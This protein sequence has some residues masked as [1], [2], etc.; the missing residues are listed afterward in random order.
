MR[1][2]LDPSDITVIV[3]TREQRPLDLSPLKMTTSSLPTGDYSIKGMEEVVAIERK[4]LSDLIGCIGRE[5]DRFERELH[6]MLAYSVRAV[7]V[8]A[9]WLDLELGQW[10]SKV[11]PHQAQASILGWMAW[12]V[13]F[14][15]AGTR[16]QSQA[17]MSR[18]LFISANREYRKAR[19][20]VKAQ[21]S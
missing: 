21:S 18:L 20:F 6:R 7:F 10:R 16:E 19:Q 12:G 14:L 13:P 2:K 9:S 1:A 4:S 11:T 17:A 15:F 8:E 5:R 3:D